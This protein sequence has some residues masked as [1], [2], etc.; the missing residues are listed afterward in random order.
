[1]LE[2][3]RVVELGVWVAG[4]SAG[5]VLADWGADVVKVESPDGDPMRRVFS[6]L[7]GHGQTA[8]PPFDLDNR[9]KRSVV[10]DLGTGPGREVVRRL[11]DGADV[12]LTNLRPEA[13]ARLG[14]DPDTLVAHDPRLVYA[15]VT[16]Y[17]RTGPDAGRAG[18]DV[19][20]FWARSGI[21]SATVPTGEHPPALRGGLGDHVSGLA[22]VGG[23]LAALYERERSGRGQLVETSLLRTGVYCLGWDLGIQLQFGKVRPTDRREETM[24]P[25]VNCYRAA[26]D[27]WF[28]LLGV[29]S[30]RLYAPLCRAIGRAELVDDDRFSTARDRRHHAAE[31]VEEL[32]A[33]FATEPR[34]RWTERFDAEDVWWAP[35]NTIA[36]VLDDAQVQAAGAFVDVPAGGDTEEH[37]AVA[38][39][40]SFGRSTIG[41]AGPVPTLGEHTDEVL[42]EAGLTAS[43]IETLRTEGALPPT[44]LSTE[45]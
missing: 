4:P 3:L 9:G 21:A 25:M 37:T 40:V 44:K 5:G 42:T 12:F 10:V 1:M 45:P 27:R 15:L 35:V 18:Y 36:E 19:G 11:V 28:W 17:G 20:A 34:D 30:Q 16:G 41:P 32:D 39:P 26:D 24:N 6:L 22:L 43:D 29:E 31:L 13:L 8:S 14:L 7:V 33:V 23:I 2:G 38:T